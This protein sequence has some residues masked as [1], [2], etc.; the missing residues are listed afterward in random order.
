VTTVDVRHQQYAESESASLAA[1]VLHQAITCGPM[2]TPPNPIRTVADLIARLQELD[3]SAPVV[4][5]HALTD[6]VD[7]IVG[8]GERPTQPGAMAVLYMPGR[9]GDA[10]KI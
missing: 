7:W 1:N 5:Q 4:A 8:V 2:T 10:P 9:P 3:P 6:Q